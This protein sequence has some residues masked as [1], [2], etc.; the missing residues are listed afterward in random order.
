MVLKKNGSGSCGLFPD[1]SESDKVLI[2]SQ[3]TV[4]LF[5]LPLKYRPLAGT[6]N[7]D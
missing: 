4:S 1:Y 2:L 5:K 7:N 3:A 6:Y